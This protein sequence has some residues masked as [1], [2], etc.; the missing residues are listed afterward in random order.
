MSHFLSGGIPRLWNFLFIKN[1][2]EKT[3]CHCGQPLPVMEDYAFT[4]A[5]GKVLNYSLAQ[6]PKCSTIFWEDGVNLEGSDS[7][8]T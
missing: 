4:F 1:L 2:P 3:T 7:D 8:V 5:C 6:C